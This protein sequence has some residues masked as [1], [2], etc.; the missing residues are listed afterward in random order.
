MIRAESA[1][2][3]LLLLFSP[4]VIVIAG[5]VLT[6]LWWRNRGT[7]RSLAL[8]AGGLDALA[9]GQFGWTILIG[10]AILGIALPVEFQTWTLGLSAL[11]PVGLALGF[12]VLYFSGWIGGR[13]SSD[14]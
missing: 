9:V 1:L 2:L 12:L 3:A 13:K 4:I 14:S 8:M 6:A 10:A 11:M 5:I 7:S